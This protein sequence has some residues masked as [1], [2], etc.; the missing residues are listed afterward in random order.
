MVPQSSLAMTFCISVLRRT[1]TRSTRI[2]P[3]RLGLPLEWLTR[4]QAIAAMREAIKTTGAKW[5]FAIGEDY[6]TVLNLQEL[7]ALP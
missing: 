2:P 5:V 4:D 7:E 3:A 1:G 6:K